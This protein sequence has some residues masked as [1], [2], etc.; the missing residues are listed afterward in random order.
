VIQLCQKQ[1][2]LNT[3]LL[4]QPR[5]TLQFPH[6]NLSASIA[7][8]TSLARRR[9]SGR[10]IQQILVKA[11]LLNYIQD[12]KAMQP[13]PPFGGYG[14]Q[15]AATRSK[16]SPVDRVNTRNTLVYYVR[17]VQRK[18]P[19][20]YLSNALSVLLLLES[21]W[22]NMG[23]KLGFLPDARGRINKFGV[24]CQN[25]SK[26][27]GFGSVWIQKSPNTVHKFKKSKNKKIRKNM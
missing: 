13:P 23:H 11:I 7:R 26:F 1:K 21:H 22:Y 4:S 17:M 3:G 27:N 19:S 9:M 2:H 14:N 6:T 15:N 8:T 25:S 16:Y 18:R 10:T 12:D 24:F 20:I 5:S